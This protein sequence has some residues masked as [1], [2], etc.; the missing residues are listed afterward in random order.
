VAG[1]AD[2]LFAQVMPDLHL[3]EDNRDILRRAA[4]LHEIGLA[5]SHSSFHKHSA[6]LLQYSDVPGFSQVDQE[7]LALVVGSCRRKIRE[8]QKMQ[9]IRSGTLSLLYVCVLLRLSAL[10][11][12]SRS[13]TPLPDLKLTGDGISFELEFPPGWLIEHPLTVADLAGETEQLR[14]WGIDFSTH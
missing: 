4:L 6:Y 10:L 5:I 14:H 8:E 13:R 9:L 7:K 1:T 3:D 12:H 11:H 2:S